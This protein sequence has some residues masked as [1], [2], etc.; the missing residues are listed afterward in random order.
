[1]DGADAPQPG[2]DQERTILSIQWRGERPQGDTRAERRD[3]LA[4]RLAGALRVHPEV[5]VDWS[6]LSLASQTV[7]I[8]VDS[9]YL[10]R[11]VRSLE[12]EGL[13]VDAVVDRQIVD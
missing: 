7:E 13:R 8:A 2:G 12:A 5:T 11:T 3:V 1:M 9:A 10:G 6:S 4:E